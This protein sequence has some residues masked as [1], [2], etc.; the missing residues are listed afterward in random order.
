M[1]G[2]EAAH[3][4]AAQT[5]VPTRWDVVVFRTMDTY[6]RDNLLWTDPPIIARVDVGHDVF[7]ERLDG[8]VARRLS[9]QCS[10]GGVGNQSAQRYSF[11]RVFP[12]GVDPQNFDEDQRLQI[13]IALSRLIRPTSVGLEESA[14]AWG[15]MNDAA[16]LVIRPGPITGP[17]SEAYVADRERPD[18]LTPADGAALR[19]L[20]DVF[21]TRGTPDRVRRGLWHHENAARSLDMAERWSSVVTGLEALFNTDPEWVTRQFKRRCVAVAGELGITLSARQADTAYRL[22]SRLS[23]GAVT[24]VPPET[25]E[26]YVAI[27]RVLRETL[28][29]GIE[30]DEWR[31]RLVDDTAVRAAWPVEM[32]TECPACRQPLPRDD[33]E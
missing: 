25:L 20:L 18:W 11:V 12:S 31:N 22:R 26:I 32:P 2:P 27:E 15:P 16:A 19:Q 4:D 1:L 14:Q 21:L 13:T 28:R 23:H 17:A 29:R 3:R 9:E 30:V 24:G 10:A 7:I 6:E 8:A 5:P 33:A